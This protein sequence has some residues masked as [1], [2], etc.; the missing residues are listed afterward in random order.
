MHATATL[1]VGHEAPTFSLKGPAGQLVSLSDYRGKRNVV[2]FFYALAFSPTCAHQLPAI[3]QRLGELKGA[4]AEV[5]GISVDSHYANEAFAKQLGLEFPLLSDFQRE[6]SA[7][8]GVLVG[9][10]GIS[11]RAV[12]VVN[13]KGTIIHKEISPAPGDPLQTPSVDRVLA[14]LRSAG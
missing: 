11:A 12:F 13:Q 10:R 7:A 3:Q 8:Y 14:A 6:V 1:E 9:D 5:M 2:L 4:G